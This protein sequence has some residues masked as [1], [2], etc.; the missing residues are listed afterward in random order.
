VGEGPCQETIETKYKR[1]AAIV[2]DAGST[3]KR[4]WQGTNRN[5]KAPRG[6]G[7]L[8]G[9][10]RFRETKTKVRIASGLASPEGFALAAHVYRREPVPVSDE[11][12]VDDDPLPVVPEFRRAPVFPIDPV[13]VPEPEP[14]IPEPE[15]VV[16]VPDPVA[17]EPVSFIPEPEPVLLVPE[18]DPLWPEP[19]RS[20]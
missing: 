15:P 10:Q 19:L 11:L 5:A 16:P 3:A 1:F 14:L 7:K 8:E 13:P 12:P 2:A 9:N 4:N 17:L 20:E 18:L 6:A